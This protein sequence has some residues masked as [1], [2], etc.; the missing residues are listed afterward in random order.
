MTL[1][2]SLKIAV[3]VI[4]QLRD[5]DLGE[6]VIEIVWV[7]ILPKHDCI[8]WCWEEYLLAEHI[9]NVWE[10]CDPRQDKKD[11]PGLSRRDNHDVDS[12]DLWL[13]DLGHGRRAASKDANIVEE[14]TEDVG[15]GHEPVPVHRLH[16]KLEHD[17]V[18]DQG[19]RDSA[20]EPMR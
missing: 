9:G 13:E 20:R 19:K 8:C 1:F 3:G 10:E 15:D 18:H 6:A 2:K 11:Y 14:K 12:A 16:E 5:K 4:L 7:A 17:G